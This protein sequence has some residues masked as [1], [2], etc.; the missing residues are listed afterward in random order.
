[1][2]VRYECVSEK[3]MTRSK[4]AGRLLAVLAGAATGVLAWRLL[5]RRRR[6]LAQREARMVPPAPMTPALQ[7][8]HPADAGL[9]TPGDNTEARLDEAIQ[10]SFPASDPV[11]IRIE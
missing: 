2:I 4:K 6:S 10:E 5:H 8:V 3:K 11:S 9:G 7:A 1:M